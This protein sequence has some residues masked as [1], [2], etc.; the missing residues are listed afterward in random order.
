MTRVIFS[1]ILLAISIGASVLGVRPWK[2]KG[3]L[4]NNAYLYASDQERSTMDKKPYYRQSA[5]VFLCVGLIFLLNA[6]SVLLKAESFSLLSIAV[7]VLTLIYA[8][9][10]DISIARNKKKTLPIPESFSESQKQTKK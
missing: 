4:F 2:E 1:G 5:F 9:A 10:S 7:A 3:K 8:I 6:I